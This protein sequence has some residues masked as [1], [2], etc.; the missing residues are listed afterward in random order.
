MLLG[1]S[2]GVCLCGFVLARGGFWEGEGGVEWSG[3]N[4]GGLDVC[5]DS[6]GGLRTLGLLLDAVADADGAVFELG[7][8]G[9]ELLEG[10]R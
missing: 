5:I 3:G 9:F 8:C 2:G 1:V 7:L 6:C 4:G 10:G